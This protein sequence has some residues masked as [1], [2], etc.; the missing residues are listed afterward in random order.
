[1]R[2]VQTAVRY[3]P[4]PGGAEAHVRAVSEGLVERGHDVEVVTSD[5]RTER[6]FDRDTSLP[7]E[8]GGVP[9]TRLPAWTPGGQGHYV[10]LRGILRDLARRAREADVLHA[11]SYGYHQ[12]W[13]GAV[14]A[15]LADVP[16]VLTPH[17]HPPWS[18]EGGPRRRRLRGLY[19][20]TLGPL[21]VGAAD[22]VL[23]VSD[24]EVDLMREAGLPV[25][26]TRPVGNGVDWDEWDPPPDGAAFRTEIGHDGPLVLFAGRLASN[27]GLPILVDAFADVAD[28]HP[29][30][31]LAL[32]GDDPGRGADLLARARDR[33]VGDPV[34]VLGHLDRDL[35]RSALAA[36][37][38]LVL[39]SEYEALGI[40][41]LEAMACSTPVVAARRGGMPE[42]V[43]DEAGLVVPYGEVPGLA[44]AIAGVLADPGKGEKMGA[45]GRERVAH[46]F[47]WEAVVDRV[48]AA[49]RDL[50]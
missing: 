22:L 29:D 31:V 44:E 8:V 11:H 13:A 42:V 2:V 23:G 25:G 5:L 38:V 6:P 26:D 19:D 32:A 15:R 18:M 7:D 50:V 34:Q 45:A 3:P 1:M 24:A 35:Y 46:R 12:T 30:A 39:P 28:E 49:Y 40:V 33:G 10:F 9:V 36:A 43:G 47:T 14:A 37:D 16:Y 41:L 21:S 17:Y 4:A 20:R 48:E 27:K